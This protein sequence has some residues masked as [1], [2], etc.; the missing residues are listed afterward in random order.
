MLLYIALLPI[1]FQDRQMMALIILIR[2]YYVTVDVTMNVNE[3]R[4]REPKLVI[5]YFKRH[6]ILN[7]KCFE[8]SG[9]C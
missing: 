5:C 9:V 8:T 3:G 7:I 2:P 6:M 1:E 4:T